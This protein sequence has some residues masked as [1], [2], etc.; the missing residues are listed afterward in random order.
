MWHRIGVTQLSNIFN[1][2]RAREAQLREQIAKEIEEV[3]V[4]TGS[5]RQNYEMITIGDSLDQIDNIT[6]FILSKCAEI[7]RGKNE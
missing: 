5:A 7:V 1:W 2:A 4:V 3:K 6:K